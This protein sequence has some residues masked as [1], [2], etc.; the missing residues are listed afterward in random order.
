MGSPP[1]SPSAQGDPLYC[2][3][4][5]PP[6]SFPPFDFPSPPNYLGTPNLPSP[7]YP[8]PPVYFPPFDFP[9]PPNY[10]GTP[11]LPSPPFS[12]PSPF[13]ILP[14]PPEFVPNPPDYAY[15]PPDYAPSPPGYAPSPPEY[16]APSPPGFV[17]NPPDYAPNPPEYAPSPPEYTAPTLPGFVPSPPDY[18]PNPPG[19][20]S[21]PPEYAPNPPENEPSPPEYVPRPIVF[22][23]PVVYPP[24]SVPP[25]PFTA[26]PN[27][28]WCVA[29]PSVPEPIIQEAMNYACGSGAD[30]D[31]ILPSGSCFQPDSVISH[32]SYAF[33]S[34][35]QRTRAAGG[36]ATSAAPPCSSP[37]TQVISLPPLFDDSS[38]SFDGCRFITILLQGVDGRG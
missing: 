13:A 3:Y 15:T 20:A 6:V 11:N 23:P 12:V 9:S 7:P 18:T 25:P 1:V 32:A 16:I 33:N 17:P 34:Y 8:P 29:K 38:P 4:P 5:P 10:L 21:S 2:I 28:L 24:P 36:P 19:Y 14:S 26:A 31:S 30:C 37:R 27:A 22:L 35:W